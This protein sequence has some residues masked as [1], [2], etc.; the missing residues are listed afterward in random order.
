MA[1]DL[2]TPSNPPAYAFIEYED[3][4]DADAAVARRDGFD[5]DGHR[6]RVELSR[7]QLGAGGG[8]GGFGGGGGYGGGGYGGG[9]YGG[10]GGR[11]GGPGAYGGGPGMMRGPPPPGR[12]GP[13]MRTGFRVTVTGLPDSSSWQDLKVGPGAAARARPRRG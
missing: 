7:R 1:I 4:R 8:R 3:P 11:P 13:P 12:M 10:G 2:K 5:F 6:L 9:G